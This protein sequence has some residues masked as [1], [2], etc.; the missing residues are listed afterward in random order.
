MKPTTFENLIADQLFKLTKSDDEF[1]N[2]M[3][4]CYDSN[5]N[6]NNRSDCKRF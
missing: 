2:Y 5:N 3:H 6:S 1:T 4:D